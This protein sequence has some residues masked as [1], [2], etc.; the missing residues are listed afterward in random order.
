MRWLGLALVAVAGCAPSPSRDADHPAA[1]P[2][3]AASPLVAGRQAAPPAALPPGLA[4]LSTASADPLAPLPPGALARLGTTRMRFRERSPLAA[5]TNA[6]T[7]L[8]VA[9]G[10][11]Q[12]VVRDLSSDKELSRGPGGAEAALAADGSVVVVARADRQE[13]EL[14]LL[15]TDG[16]V[17]W[18]TRLQAPEELRRARGRQTKG[19]ASLRSVVLSPDAARVAVAFRS[20]DVLTLDAHSGAAGPRLRVEGAELVELS[21]QGERAL[22]VEYLANPGDRSLRDR[23]TIAALQVLDVGKGTILRRLEPK[24]PA[25]IALSPDGREILALTKNELVAIDVAT[26]Q[27]R[28]VTPVEAGDP[29]DLL[30]HLAGVGSLL[31]SPD[32]TRA[33]MVGSTSRIVSLADGTTLERLEHGS[34]LCFSA[35]GRLLL[36]RNEDEALLIGKPFELPLGHAGPIRDFAFAARGALIV[37]LASDVRFW[38]AVRGVELGR[39]PSA[40]SSSVLGSDPDARHL[41]LEAPHLAELTED[42]RVVE[43]TTEPAQL[44]H[45]TP[46]VSAAAPLPDGEHVVVVTRASLFE[47]DAA[48]VRLWS[49]LEPKELAHAAVEGASSLVLDPTGQRVAVKGASRGPSQWTV[50]SLPDLGRAEA[51]GPEAQELRDLAFVGGPGRVFGS[52]SAGAGAILYDLPSGTVVQRFV[53]GRCCTRV[54]AS[55]D[56]RLVAGADEQAIHLWQVEPL[57]L[58]AVFEGHRAGIAKLA[59]SPDGARLVSASKDST[60]LVWDTSARVGSGS[61]KPVE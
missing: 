32:G 51:M 3:R 24:V 49:M 26:G 61:P 7:A 47:D 6:G 37:S 5:V 43:L 55:R 19:P 8:E 31:V 18:T 44:G 12:S 53:S 52:V 23:D 46:T 20:G 56:G 27:R 22:F 17:G 41:V 21:R 42:G 40:G 14:R 58:L 10:W 11:E 57:R 39:A 9:V 30:A 54:A 59:F 60:M 48:G 50:L 33:A 13:V 36:A 38:D 35:D 16:A 29:S 45:I 4:P 34:P 2:P 25:A 1:P 28:V 15:H